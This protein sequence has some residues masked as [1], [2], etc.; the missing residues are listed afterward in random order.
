M[1]KLMKK[2]I[3]LLLGLSTVCFA[4]D[5][6]IETKQIQHKFYMQGECL[7]FDKCYPGVGIG[8]RYHKNHHGFDASLNILDETS[9]HILPLWKCAYLFYPHDSFY[10]G[11]GLGGLFEFYHHRPHPTIPWPYVTLG[12]DIQIGKQTKLFIQLDA[13]S[14]FPIIPVMGLGSIGISF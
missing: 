4:E 13:S 9:Y 5:L 12:K 6:K 8:Y 2:M 7:F 11:P 10:W 1:E 14:L 3:V